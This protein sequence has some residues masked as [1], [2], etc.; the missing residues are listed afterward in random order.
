MQWHKKAK[1]QTST[2]KWKKNYMEN[3]KNKN[4]N[5]ISHAHVNIHTRNL[6]RSVRWCVHYEWNMHNFFCWYNFIM[7]FSDIYNL[8]WKHPL[9]HSHTNKHTLISSAHF[10]P[11]SFSKLLL[12]LN[13]NGREKK[14]VKIILVYIQIKNKL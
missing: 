2:K 10:F 11:F 5:E 4:D 6:S 14:N 8:N 3:E 13:D 1:L 12:K 9:T 7:L